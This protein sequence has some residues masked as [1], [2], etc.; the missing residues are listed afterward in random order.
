V[1]NYK[2][3]TKEGTADKSQGNVHVCPNC[4]KILQHPPKIR[5]QNLHTTIYKKEL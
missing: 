2:K 4:L 3:T 1:D 5:N